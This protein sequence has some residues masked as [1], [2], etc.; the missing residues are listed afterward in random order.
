MSD[1]LRAPAELKYAEELDWLES[2]DDGTKPFTWRLSPKMIRLFVLGS[3][4]ADGLDREISQKWF[5]DRAIVE[6]A[7]VTLASD[8]GLLLIGDPGTGKSWLA[9]L[10]AAAICRNSTL[11]VQGTAGT[12]EDHIKYSWNVSQVIAKGQSRESMIPSPIMTAMEAGAIGRVEELTRST[13]DVQDALI[14][15]LSEKYISVPELDSDNIVFAKPGFSVIATANSRDRGVN[16]LSSALK[17]RFN[18]V[19]IPVVTNKKSEAEIVRFRTEELLRRHQIELD[20]PPTLLDVLLQSFADL[21]ASSA[22]AGSDDEKL[23][24]ALST[25]EQIGVLEDA[26]LHSNFFGQQALT[27]HTLASSL[28]GSLARRAPEDLAILNKYLHGVVEPRGKEEGGCWP[29]FLEGGR[30]AIATLS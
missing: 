6:R 30:A 29:E 20:V 2:A 4:R 21:R 8:R 15:I 19:R 1:L 23:E 7:I 16:D 28:V 17:R 26:I 14:S 22:A 10:L 13:S 3:E 11:V 24:S 5:G 18:F 9:E 25:A 27:A 12:T